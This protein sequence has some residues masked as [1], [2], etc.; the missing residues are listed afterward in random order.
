[1]V[2]WTVIVVAVW[3]PADAAYAQSS[4]D[5]RLLYAIYEADHPVFR[6]TMRAA[7]ASSYPVFLG[8]PVVAWGGIGLLRQEGPWDDAYRLTLS[9]ATATVS[10]F[11]VKH[12][13]RRSRPY[14]TLPDVHSRS[15]RYGVGKT[16]RDPFSFPSGHAA[17]SVALASS[18]SLSHPEWYVVAPSILWASSVSLS[19]VWLGVHYPTD[20]LAGAV[21]GTA[22]ALVVH[23]LGPHLTP[24]G[25]E[26]ETAIAPPALML[27]LRF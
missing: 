27:R 6:T 11:A 20:V 23:A 2:R 14:A 22:I 5:Q 16:T 24:S 8:A 4:L 19:R 7:E 25:L 9:A 17:L 26:K 10:V 12:L 21:L 15:P 18:W 1:M 13:V 3:L